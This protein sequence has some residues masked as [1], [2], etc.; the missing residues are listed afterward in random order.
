MRAMS[1]FA[2]SDVNI[3][4]P[5]VLV[6][7]AGKHLGRR[8][9][10]GKHTVIL[11]RDPECDV[12][13]DDRRVSRQHA[14]IEPEDDGSLLLVDNG[15]SNGTFLN[16]EPI[17]E[18]HLDLGDRIG[19]GNG[20]QLTLAHFGPLVERTVGLQR[21]AARREGLLYAA[22]RTA[23]LF[24]TLL[25]LTNTPTPEGIDAIRSLA[26][27]GLLTTEAF[28][29]AS[30][31]RPEQ[32]KSVSLEHVFDD[33][34]E[35]LGN[36]VHVHIEHDLTL[37]AD[38]LHLVRALLEL[39]KHGLLTGPVRF[40]VDV[41]DLEDG[42]SRRLW[43]APGAYARV[44]LHDGSTTTCRADPGEPAEAGERDLSVAAGIFRAHEGHLGV[45][46]TATGTA[47]IV[48]LPLA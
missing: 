27:Q 37:T 6:Q 22:A 15:S 47:I 24:E 43:L 38:H 35:H 4:P 36:E 11:G 3:D 25:E 2:T 29:L 19:L 16:G 39:A 31:Q 18:Q 30:G 33:V 12:P 34:V 40:H 45:Q 9:P 20:V 48:Y 13:I 23:P 17:S 8:Y 1:P 41:I 32:P 26:R 28:V 5:L 7:T 46:V 10:L 44:T 42:D 21:T 14:R